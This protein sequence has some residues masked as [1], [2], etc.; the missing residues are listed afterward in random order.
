MDATEH[1]VWLSAATQFSKRPNSDGHDAQYVAVMR[2]LEVEFGEAQLEGMLQSA[3]KT[4]RMQSLAYNRGEDRDLRT[5]APAPTPQ[6]RASPRR[7][8]SRKFE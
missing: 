3:L 5:R 4:E 6:S 7:R 8:A 2:S 1:A